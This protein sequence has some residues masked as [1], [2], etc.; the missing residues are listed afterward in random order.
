LLGGL[1]LSIRLGY[2]CVL[3]QGLVPLLAHHIELLPKGETLLP[4]ANVSGGNTLLQSLKGRF[5]LALQLCK[6]LLQPG[7]G[8]V[9][10]RPDYLQLLL[11]R[12][13]VLIQPSL[14]GIDPL[15]SAK[16]RCLMIAL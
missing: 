4:D 15:I 12:F 10:L 8:G 2:R 13:H 16:Q 5:M 6:A 7:V 9:P 11:E 1:F 14:H 3:G